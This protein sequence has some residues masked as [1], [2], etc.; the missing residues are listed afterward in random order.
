MAIFPGLTKIELLC[1]KIMS[2]ITTQIKVY[3]T[4]INLGI[5]FISHFPDEYLSNLRVDKF[6]EIISSSLNKQENHISKIIEFITISC[7]I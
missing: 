3:I 1:F 4:T 6:Y 5:N 2:L 7:F